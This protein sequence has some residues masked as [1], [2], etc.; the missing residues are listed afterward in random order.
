MNQIEAKNITKVYRTGTGSVTALRDVSFVVEEEAFVAF[1]GP[2]GC[3]KSTLLQILAGLVQPTKGRVVYREGQKFDRGDIGY[4]FQDYALLPWK[5]VAGNLKTFLR[6][7]QLYP[8]PERIHK[9]LSMV[10]LEDY[11]D[12][13]PYE[14]SGGMQQRVAVA[15]ALVTDPEVVLMDE[16]FAALDALTKERLYGEFTAILE[17][18]D[19]T[20]VYVTHDIEEAYR[21]ADRLM[22][23]SSGGELVR[24]IDLDGEAPRGEEALSRNAFFSVKEQV[25][26]TIQAGDTA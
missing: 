3:G 16:P 11:A 4:V 25:L 14:L 7:A 18:A 22:L 24:E 19:K 23:L 6:L 13:Y 20:V 12:A 15:R 21:F 2:S 17:Q 1:L 26:D 5:T 10:G 8:D 9:H